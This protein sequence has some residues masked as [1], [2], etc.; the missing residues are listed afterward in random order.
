LETP[1]AGEFAL[2]LKLAKRYP[3]SGADIPDLIVMA[4]ASMRRASV[5][6]WDF[7]HFRAVVLR[8]RHHWPLVVDEGELPSP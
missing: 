8:R 7:R 1:A 2:A 4:M 6:T 5:L 3:D